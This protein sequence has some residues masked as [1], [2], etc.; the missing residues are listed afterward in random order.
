MTTRSEPLPA[1]LAAAHAMILAQREQLTLAK[2]EVAVG[3]CVMIMVLRRACYAISRPIRQIGR[4]SSPAWQF[5]LASATLRCR[6]RPEWQ[7]PYFRCRIC[8]GGRWQK[9]GSNRV[10]RTFRAS[11]SIASRIS[12]LRIIGPYVWC[13]PALLTPTPRLAP[14]SMSKASC[15]AIMIWCRLDLR[16]GRLYRGGHRLGRPRNLFNN[17]VSG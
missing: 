13:P 11:Q 15:A 8:G 9:S 10:A 3:L 7:R 6:R 2:S 1:D 16:L 17:N 12:K 5:S 4:D 14:R